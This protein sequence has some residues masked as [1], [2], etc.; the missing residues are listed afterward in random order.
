MTFSCGTPDH[1]QE[2]I[3][4]FRENYHAFQTAANVLS[5][6]LECLNKMGKYVKYSQ[7]S[8]DSKNALEAIRLER[9]A[10][11][12]LSKSDCI[13]RSRVE[14]IFDA[15]WE[16][17][18]YPCGAN[19]IAPGEHIEMNKSFIEGWGLDEHW[20]LWVNRDVIG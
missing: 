12:T 10:Y 4:S 18:Y 19:D 5:S 16:L 17:V 8:V 11:V 14:I 2:I 15:N 13:D 7:L 20:S 1:D 6:D 3:T 9:V